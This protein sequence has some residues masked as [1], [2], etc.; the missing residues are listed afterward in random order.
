MV[1]EIILLIIAARRVVRNLH[2]EGSGLF[3]ILEKISNDL[4]PD[5]NGSLVSLSCFFRQKRGDLQKKQVFTKI[6][7]VFS[8]KIR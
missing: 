3:W 1:L 6:E 4:D 5:F 8:A 7:M 2:W